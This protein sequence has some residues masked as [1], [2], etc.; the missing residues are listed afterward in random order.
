[1]ASVTEKAKGRTTCKGYRK[2]TS[3]EKTDE[4][5]PKESTENKPISVLNLKFLNEGEMFGNCGNVRGSR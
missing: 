1:M 2:Q 3:F 4:K 5:W